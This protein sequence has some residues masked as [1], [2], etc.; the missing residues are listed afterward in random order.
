MC[1]CVCVHAIQP[2]SICTCVRTQPAGGGAATSAAAA[3]AG[4]KDTYKD[5][6]MGPPR[7]VPPSAK[8]AAP[9][10]AAMIGGVCAFQCGRLGV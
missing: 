5:T 6:D 4:A 10:A 8:T 1:M 3:L 2:L 9:S 7:A